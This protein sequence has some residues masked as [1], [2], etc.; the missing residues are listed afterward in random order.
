MTLSV[1]TVTIGVGTQGRPESAPVT[2][3]PW[4]SD[5]QLVAH[6]S[7]TEAIS[8]VTAMVFA[9]TGSPFF[10]A[11][12]SEM[13]EPRQFQKSLFLCQGVV[14]VTFITIGVVTYYYCGSYV[15]SPA[16]G[17]AGKT[18]KIA[19]YAIALPGLCVSATLSAHV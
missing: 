11:M 5:W 19:A 6:P 3:S 8:A 1:L 16:L 15:A 4:R 9:L 18:V 2:T 17:S 13:R 12:I 7:F 10:F 14:V